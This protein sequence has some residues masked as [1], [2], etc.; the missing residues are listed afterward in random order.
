MVE[1]VI[2]TKDLNSGYGKLQILFDIDIELNKG[3]LVT[4]IGPNGSGKSTLIKTIIG[5]VPAWSGTVMINQN[6]N[7]TGMKPYEI[8][9]SGIPINYVPQVANVFPTL[10]VEENLKLG[11]LPR[12]NDPESMIQ[13]DLDRMFGI[14]PV[15]QERIDQKAALLSGGEKQM[16]ALARALMSNPEI[17]LLDEPSAALA[18]I[19]ADQIFEKILELKK[20]GLSIILVEQ[21]ATRALKISDRGYVLVSGQVAIS[22]A[23]KMLIDNEKVGEL[24]LGKR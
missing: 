5:L 6:I 13:E 3:E 20:L 19:L 23:A 7:I 18:P 10:S 8:V 2:E 17:I 24:Y 16:L 21:R 9:T 14:F 1:Q 11:A 15:L 22:G 4:I 12:D